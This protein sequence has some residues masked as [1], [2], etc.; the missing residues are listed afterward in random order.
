MWK[1]LGDELNNSILYLTN[2]KNNHAKK[3][4]GLAYSQGNLAAYP[5]II[6]GIARYLLIQYP[7]NK[8]TN[9]RDDKMGDKKKEDNPKS[10]DKD[11]NMVDTVDAHVEDTTTTEEST[12]PNRGATREAILPN[13]THTHTHTHTNVKN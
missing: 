9:Q 10:E 12:L 7:N 2:L 13:Y 3:D 11:N 8:S 1:E 5:P 6:E 4:L